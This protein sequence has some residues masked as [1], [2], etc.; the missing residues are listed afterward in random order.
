MSVSCTLSLIR[1]HASIEAE[2][3]EE[4]GGGGGFYLFDGIDT[5]YI[6]KTMKAD[7]L[8]CPTTTNEIKIG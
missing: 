1:L 4:K 8:L 6:Q 3:E 2:V 5:R 7:H